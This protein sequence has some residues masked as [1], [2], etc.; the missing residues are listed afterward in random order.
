MK[1]LAVAIDFSEVT[2]AVVEQAALLARA[3]RAHLWLIHVAAEP[4][5]YEAGPRTVRDRRALELRVEHRSL[6]ALTE[7]LRAEKI[8]ATALLVSG[9]TVETILREAEKTK[10]D[11]IVLGSHGHGFLRRALLGSVSEGVLHDARRPVLIV[12][13]AREEAGPEQ[14]GRS[15][16]GGV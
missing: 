12:P 16:A 8:E 10:A 1:N 7:R 11:L 6:Q 2:G 4:D 14:A 3:L 13:S 9:P 5:L 15:N